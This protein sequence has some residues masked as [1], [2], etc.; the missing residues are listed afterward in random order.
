M[1]I[2]KGENQEFSFEANE[3]YEIDKILVDGKNI[4]I[5]DSYTFENVTNSHKIEVKFK[6]ISKEISEEVSGESSGDVFEEVFYTPSLLLVGEDILFGRQFL[7]PRVRIFDRLGIQNLSNSTLY[8][9]F[10]PLLQVSH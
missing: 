4:E 10:F 3:G 9:I 2:K 1:W 7:V 5:T 6:E 8:R